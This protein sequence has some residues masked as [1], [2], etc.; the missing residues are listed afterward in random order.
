[1]FLIIETNGKFIFTFQKFKICVAK[2]KLI[3]TTN[4]AAGDLKLI[5]NNKVLFTVRRDPEAIEPF[6]MNLQIIKRPELRNVT[7]TLMHYRI[8]HCPYK[9]FKWNHQQ[10]FIWRSLSTAWRNRYLRCLQSKQR[11][12]VHVITN[13]SKQLNLVE[14]FEQ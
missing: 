9:G 10:R 12:Q 14:Q 7:V 5:Y 1:M 6:Q 8:G 3:K 13:S 11:E 2:Q 4:V